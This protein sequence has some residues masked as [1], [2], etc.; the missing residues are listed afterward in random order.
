M[1][2]LPD[3][4]ENCIFCPY[5]YTLNHGI[6]CK[7]TAKHIKHHEGKFPDFCPLE[8]MVTIKNNYFI[9]GKCE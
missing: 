5:R 3:K 2:K 7:L 6:L 1:R 9:R 4:I 8:E